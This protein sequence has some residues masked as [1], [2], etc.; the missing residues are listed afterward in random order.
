MKFR[1]KY[2]L[3]G[4]FVCIIDHGFCQV[5]CEKTIALPIYRPTVQGEKVLNEVL[6]TANPNVPESLN[7][8]FRISK[9]HNNL[10]VDFCSQ[11]TWN[12]I[13]QNYWQNYFGCVLFKNR[14]FLLYRDFEAK[15]ICFD[16]LFVSTNNS[17]NFVMASLIF[18][19][20]DL[21]DLTWWFSK[22]DNTY[23]FRGIKLSTGLIQDNMNLEEFD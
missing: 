15:E 18:V 2:F 11:H 9:E 12:I 8:I 5:S 13:D 23:H 14:I 16:D 4:L 3:V 17:M 22:S 20:D 7:G 1:L 21:S 10:E 19:I 6:N